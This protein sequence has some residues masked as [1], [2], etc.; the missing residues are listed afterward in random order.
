MQN[1]VLVRLA[2]DKHSS[3]LVRS[4]GEEKVF[5]YCQQLDLV[6]T[7]CNEK[8]SVICKKILMKQPGTFVINLLCSS[9]MKG[10]NKLVQYV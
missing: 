7:D 5:Q 3:L 4:I 10:Q 2:G 6:T 8:H 9:P 1:I